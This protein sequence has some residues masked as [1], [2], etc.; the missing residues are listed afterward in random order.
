MTFI[1]ASGHSPISHVLDSPVRIGGQV[2]FNG[3]TLQVVSLFIGLA[4][5]LGVL[6]FASKNIKTGPESMGHRRYLSRGRIAQLIEVICLY[7]RDEMLAP[8]MGKKDAFKYA[9]FLLT[10]FF[11]ILA[12]NLFGMIPLQD[13]QAITGTWLQDAELSVVGGT[14][15][16]NITVN[17]VLA[18]FVF[19]VVQV[20]G[21]R[22]LGLKGWLEH[23]CGGHELVAGPKPLLL[24]VPM[25]FLVELMGLIIKPSALC[26]RLFAN[27]FG[28]HTLLATFLMFGGMTWAGTQNGWATGGVTLL[29][30]LFA[31]AITFMELFVAFLQAFVFMFLSAVFIS[32]M[33][34]HDEEHAH[35]EHDVEDD[36]LAAAH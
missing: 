22:E 20:H 19:I 24:V 8:M 16:A 10:L 4:L 21:L 1:L 27:M 29:S 28:G 33:S 25:I 9:P 23:L 5:F 35:E 6:L 11:L 17:A 12:L 31:V 32:L 18:F 14:A 3:L 2:P 26:I 7:L 36:I 30:G 15:T 34:H 13:M